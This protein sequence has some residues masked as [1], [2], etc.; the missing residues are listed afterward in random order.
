MSFLVFSK[1]KE[2][3]NDLLKEKHFLL[4][5]HTHTHTL[6]TSRAL[7]PV[8]AEEAEEPVVPVEPVEPEVPVGHK[9]LHVNFN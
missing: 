7:E 4:H 6:Q 9:R 5:R 2:R 8:E 1:V 3:K